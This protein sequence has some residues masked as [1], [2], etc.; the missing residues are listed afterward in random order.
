ML[1]SYKVHLKK[2]NR[3]INISV[4]EPKFKDN[5]KCLYLLDGQNAFKDTKTIFN[6]SL[7]LISII[8]YLSTLNINIMAI[9][10]ESDQKRN[11]EYS[12]FKIKNTAILKGGFNDISYNHNFSDDVI[13]SIIPFIENKYNIKPDSNNRI[14]YGSSLAAIESLYL[15]LNYD[16][17]N[18]IGL[19]STASFIY[20]NEFNN[21]I[22]STINVNKKVFIYVGS[23][24]KSDNEFMP[25]DYL[26]AANDL[27]MLLDSKNIKN[28]LVINKIGRHNEKS[29]SYFIP[30]FLKY[31]FE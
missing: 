7:R 27:K 3:K 19:F 2:S 14:I 21:F 24:E 29:W 23:H 22:L 25:I 9:G 6:R 1:R 4:Y 31:V 28:K 18:N 26:N 12:P 13:E 16:A 8:N 17:F 10:I 20:D 30:D 11:D 15:G 5:M